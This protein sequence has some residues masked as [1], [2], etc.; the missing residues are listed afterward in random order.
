MRSG[1]VFIFFVTALV[2]YTA[3]SHYKGSEA[4]ISIKKS[5]EEKLEEYAIKRFPYLDTEWFRVFVSDNDGK[6]PHWAN[7]YNGISALIPHHSGINIFNPYFAGLNYETIE[8]NGVEQELFEPR[9]NPISI[10][11]WTDKK[12]VLVQPET[13]TSHVS[14][15]ITF[16]V[17][18]PWYLHQT[19]ELTFHQ[20]IED[21]AG[22]SKFSSLF[23]SYI[24]LPEDNHLY[25]RKDESSENLLIGWIGV[26]RETHDFGRKEYIVKHLPGD[27]ELKAADHLLLMRQYGINTEKSTESPQ[28]EEISGPLPFYYGLLYDGLVFLQMFKQPDNVELAYSPTGGFYGDRGDGGG[29]VWSPA[30]DYILHLDKVQVGVTYR[31]DVCVLVKPFN[32]REDILKE[33]DRYINN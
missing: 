14:A 32:G 28:L 5:Y 17:E 24:H 1:I 30:W 23:A 21:E 25:L 27:K 7:G 19:I 18:E 6:G 33:V 29:V 10:E 26:T 16:R 31:W 12:V 8:I 4:G 15:R 13:S 11:E 3:C 2:N 22:N 20:A 9:R